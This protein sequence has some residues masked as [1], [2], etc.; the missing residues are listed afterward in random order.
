MVAACCLSHL[1]AASATYH[2]ARRTNA[3]PGM[4]A[5]TRARYCAARGAAVHAEA[6][7]LL[8]ELFPLSDCAWAEVTSLAASGGELCA[9]RGATGDYARGATGAAGLRDPAQFA[10]HSASDD[11]TE[12]SLLL[13][14]NG[15]HVELVVRPGDTSRHPAGLVDVRL[16]SAL[17]TIVDL[18]DSACTV[19]A[20][21][22]VAAY[23]NWLGLMRRSLSAPLLKGGVLTERRLAPPRTWS[24]GG[25]EGSGAAE[26][27]TTS[28]VTL[29]GQALLLCRNVGMHMMTDAVL[30]CGRPV[31]EHFVD[32]LVTAACAVH[33]TQQ[34]REA[35]IQ[36]RQGGD[37]AR[38]APRA[39][40]SAAGSVY[41]VKPK[42]HGPEECAHAVQQA[43]GECPSW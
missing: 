31:P 32:A 42:M 23:A 27:A 10:A 37:A 16:E 34:S 25:Q 7:D 5:A 21:D 41:V 30:A 19:D 6:H 11:G 43:C 14:R 26:G 3:V 20:E 9:T 18:E 15:L 13:T 24:S 35:L 22:K 36:H 29:P 1:V 17:S 39:V 8:D 12:L 4:P 28:G 38:R 40:N 33:D 2:V